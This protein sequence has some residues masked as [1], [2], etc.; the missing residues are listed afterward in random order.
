[1][2]MD[3]RNHLK[4]L[5]ALLS[6]SLMVSTR[7]FAEK[8]FAPGDQPVSSRRVRYAF[9]AQNQSAAVLEQPAVLVH[10]PVRQTSTQRVDALSCTQ[11]SLVEVDLFGNQT[12][13]VRL[14]PLAPYATRV[15]TVDAELMLSDPPRAEALPPLLRQSYRVAERYV[16]TTDP[17]IQALI[18]RLKSDTATHTARNIFDF[19]RRGL[20]ADEYRGIERGAAGAL[21]ERAGTCADHAYLFTALM[22]AAGYPARAVGGYIGSDSAMLRAHDYH[23]WAEFYDEGT[24]RLADPHQGRFMREPARY[25]AMRIVSSQAP[26]SLGANQRYAATRAGLLVSMN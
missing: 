8:P 23:T 19:V 18:P 3:R 11:P 21:Q 17:R 5:G 15:V 13:R 20:R 4:V 12:L 9:T 14:E 26:G 22:R 10:A 1:M 25:I 16:E 2:M 7:T 6:G 24:W